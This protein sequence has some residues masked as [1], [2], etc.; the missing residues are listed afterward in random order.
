LLI[1]CAN[2][3]NLQLARECPPSRGRYPRGPRR[4]RW[5]LIRGLLVESV[6]LSGRHCLAVLVA[7]GASVS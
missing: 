5:R 1:A 3:A 7:C 6:V 2:V 4:Y